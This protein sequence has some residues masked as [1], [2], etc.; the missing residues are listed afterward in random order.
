MFVPRPEE[1][2]DLM[3]ARVRFRWA[4][5]RQPFPTFV[6]G[7]PAGG[8]PG[9][10]ADEPVPFAVVVRHS[11]EGDFGALTL[12]FDGR[13]PTP[14]N[15][16]HATWWG[17]M[18]GANRRG[19][20]A[21][22]EIEDFLEGNANTP[23][24]TVI[25]GPAG[26]GPEADEDLYVLTRP[27]GLDEDLAT[28]IARLQ[29]RVTRAA[30]NACLIMVHHGRTI[31]G[32]AN[33]DHTARLRRLLE[34]RHVK[35]AVRQLNQSALDAVPLLYDFDRAR[36]VGPDIPDPRLPADPTGRRHRFLGRK[37]HWAN[38]AHG[39]GHSLRGEK[40]GL[41]TWRCSL[42]PNTAHLAFD[43]AELR[44]AYRTRPPQEAAPCPPTSG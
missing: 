6:V 11:P 14:Q 12:G 40:D 24:R 28:R 9:Q 21:D 42:P 17:G 1:F 41:R 29:S 7:V 33:P 31:L 35:P 34:K 38:L 44:V 10:Q 25:G 18:L 22:R 8:L 27:V 37:G 39:P 23:V 43:P 16:G 30:L 36:L 2:T 26:D 3:E 5:Y 13:V 4:E 20:Q 19:E 15:S 32:S